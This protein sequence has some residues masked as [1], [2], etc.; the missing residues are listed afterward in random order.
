MTQEE[1]DRFLKE[2]KQM[3]QWSETG[4]EWYINIQASDFDFSWECEDE[5]EYKQSFNYLIGQ[6]LK[7]KEI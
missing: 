5:E 3:I 1:K 2:I 6:L 4:R 7:D